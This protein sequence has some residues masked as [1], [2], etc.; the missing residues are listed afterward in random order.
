MQVTRETIIE[1]VKAFNA[2][3]FGGELPLDRIITRV[4]NARTYLGNVRY[5]VENGIRF[6]TLSISTRFQFP[7]SEIEDTIIHEMIHIY[8]RHKG[9]QDTSTHGIEF[10]RIMEHINATYG[11]HITISHHLTNNEAS[12]DTTRRRHYICVIEKT[13]GSTLF[14][15]CSGQG[16]FSI[17]HQLRINP[18]IKAIKWY[19]STDP[20]F[21]RYPAR[22]TPRFYPLSHEVTTLLGSA[23]PMT[24]SP[25]AKSL[26]PTRL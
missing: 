6:Y 25:D 12:S 1:R 16:T 13:D 17:Y 26:R 9:I 21:N 14:T 11:R 24:M 5:T 23:T 7:D 20:F 19:C 22:R 8:I 4:S 3:Y 10:R 2:L 15:C 18:N